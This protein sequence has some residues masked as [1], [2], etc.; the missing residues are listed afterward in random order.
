MA[1]KTGV[2]G[3]A[4]VAGPLKKRFYFIAASLSRA[5]IRLRLRPLHIILVFTSE[6]IRTELNSVKSTL[7]ATFNQYLMKRGIKLKIYI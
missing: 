6:N 1:T 2:G 7:N 3:K 4:L 5:S